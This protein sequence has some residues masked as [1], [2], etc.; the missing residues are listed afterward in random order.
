MY[1]SKIILSINI[2]NDYLESQKAT[3]EL[4]DLE[5]RNID[6]V[7]AILK[8]LWSN[9]II[10]LHKIDIRRII[11]GFDEYSVFMKNIL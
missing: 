8:E 3:K 11:A 6:A 7:F 1:Y 9:V 2:Y 10:N 4:I 5:K